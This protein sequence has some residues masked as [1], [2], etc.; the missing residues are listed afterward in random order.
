[1]KKWIVLLDFGQGFELGD[2]FETIQ[3]V[4]NFLTNTYGEWED[5]KI[6]QIP[7]HKK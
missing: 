7:S 1:M 3:E 5:Y 2:V 4:E 6:V